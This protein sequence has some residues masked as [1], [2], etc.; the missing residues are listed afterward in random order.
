MNA[1]LPVSLDLA[2]RFTVTDSTG[3]ILRTEELKPGTNLRDRL[4]LAHRNYQLQGWTVDPLLIGHWRF[5]AEKA[6]RRIVTEIQRP[7]SQPP[8]P[9][10]ALTDP[11]TPSEPRVQDIRHLR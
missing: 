6:G 7:H 3:R 2:T 4:H 11:L 9:T 5:R 10:L 1:P 8:A